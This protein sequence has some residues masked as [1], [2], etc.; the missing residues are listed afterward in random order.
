MGQIFPSYLF[1]GS[2]ICLLSIQRE[3]I[4]LGLFFSAGATV[5]SPSPA[6]FFVG[7]IID[8]KSSATGAS[9]GNV[10]PFSHGCV[11]SKAL[12]EG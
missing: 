8:N 2:R 3:E 11:A 4:S 9:L 6:G 12:T 5:W 7:D 1:H 10:T